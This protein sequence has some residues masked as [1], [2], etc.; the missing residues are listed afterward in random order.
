MRKVHAD[1]AR[2][3]FVLPWLRQVLTHFAAKYTEKKKHNAYR[4]HFWSLANRRADKSTLTSL[5]LTH[6]LCVY[7]LLFWMICTLTFWLCLTK[8]KLRLVCTVVR[9][10]RT[11]TRTAQRTTHIYTHQ[12][13][14]IYNTCECVFEC[15]F[16]I[17][18]HISQK[19][20]VF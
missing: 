5:I 11:H 9:F 4:I 7:L 18:S 10:V 14:Y 13:S 6:K 20:R 3:L 17:R 8:S 16:D 19:Q 12:I 1:A 15:V 2:Q